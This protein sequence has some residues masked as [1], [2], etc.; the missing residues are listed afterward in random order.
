M[1]TTKRA[2]LIFRFPKMLDEDF[3]KITAKIKL[4]ETPNEIKG[5]KVFYNEVLR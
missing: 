1:N 4:D 3:K 2:F 5:W